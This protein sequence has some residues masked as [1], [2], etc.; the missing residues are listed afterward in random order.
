M[1]SQQ[2]LNPTR[3][4][5]NASNTL[6]HRQLR[7]GATAC[8]ATS[9][10]CA[11]CR[12]ASQ[13]PQALRHPNTPTAAL[14]PLLTST[15]AVVVRDPLAAEE[16]ACAAQVVRTAD[17]HGLPVGEAKPVE[18]RAVSG[19]KWTQSVEL[20]CRCYRHTAQL[21]LAQKVALY[22]IVRQRMERMARSQA[23]LGVST[24]VQRFR[25]PG[26]G[27]WAW[28]FVALRLH[29]RHVC[30][31]GLH[32]TVNTGTQWWY[33]AGSVNN[34]RQLC[35]V[36]SIARPGGLA[37]AQHVPGSGLGCAADHTQ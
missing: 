7:S 18:G 29:Y 28:P 15:E 16:D 34:R 22:G 1:R 20:C 9:A 35:V 33:F 14:W 23:G 36:R 6:P 10:R 26:P 11:S 5:S 21:H 19:G 31:H 25:A 4:A 32:C 37:P 24:R 12:Q 27:L 13:V 17:G 8:I 2:L 3:M 30:Q